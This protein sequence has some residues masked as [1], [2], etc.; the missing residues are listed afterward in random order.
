M[1]F[2]NKIAKSLVVIGQNLTT[3]SMAGLMFTNDKVSATNAIFALIVSLGIL[4]TGHFL[5]KREE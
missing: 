4:L 3:L 1:K 5:K 2:F